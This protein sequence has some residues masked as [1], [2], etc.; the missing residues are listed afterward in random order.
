[1]FIGSGGKIVLREIE[2]VPF[3]HNFAYNFARLK[4]SWCAKY[5]KWMVWPFL[6][7]WLYRMG[8]LP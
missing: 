5:D 8:C 2:P 7:F 1:M 4:L 6:T 3:L